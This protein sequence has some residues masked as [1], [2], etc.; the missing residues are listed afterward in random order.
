MIKGTTKTQPPRLT[1]ERIADAALKL[2]DREG[3][4]ALSMRRLGG[5]LG[6]AAMSLYEYFASKEELLDALVDRATEEISLPGTDGHWRL[7]M[8]ELAEELR[9]VLERHPSGVLIRFTRP[10]LSPG[11]MKVT[12]SAMQILQ[13]GGFSRADAARAYRTI[14]LYTFAYASFAGGRGDVDTTA[15]AESALLT[16]PADT[17]PAVRAGA[18][19]LAQTMVG[20]VQFRW[21]LDR[22]LDGLELSRSEVPTAR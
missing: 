21:G 4:E 10:M 6:V 1:R 18:R 22:I 13:G 8:V 20:D 12:E 9:S 3:I 19:E 16:L 14:F 5:E 7:R 2:A 17:F 15:T 11:A